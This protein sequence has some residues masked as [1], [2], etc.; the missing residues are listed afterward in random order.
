MT[1]QYAIT[2]EHFRMNC[3]FGKYIITL[4]D[5]KNIDYISNPM[6][7]IIL[8]SKLTYENNIV[9][10]IVRSIS[11]IYESKIIQ[12]YDYDYLTITKNYIIKDKNHIYINLPFQFS[13]NETKNLGLPL[14]ALDYKR[15]TITCDTQR[16]YDSL[17]QCEL[18][19]DVVHTLTPIPKKTYKWNYNNVE[20]CSTRLNKSHQY[21]ND[22]YY[23][24]LLCATMTFNRKHIGSDMIDHIFEYLCISKVRYINVQ[25]I[26]YCF[27]NPITELYI[28]IHDKHNNY[29]P[30]ISSITLHYGNY[31][32]MEYN[33]TQLYSLN[34]F[35]IKKNIINKVAYIPLLN[36]DE[37][38]NNKGVMLDSYYTTF[39]FN[40]DWLLLR[41][42]EYVITMYGVGNDYSTI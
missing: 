24:S 12:R 40:I 5:L 29:I 8:S 28:G 11:V 14:H 18:L 9:N 16:K 31:S 10:L 22:L 6:L 2:Q 30:S 26:K 37:E 3:D 34:K 35:K 19:A 15:L 42:E 36:Y 33:H 32:R 23:D 39:L 13:I 25:T 4:N 38:G 21:K 27:Q 41:D 1:S 20:T 17:I 7:H